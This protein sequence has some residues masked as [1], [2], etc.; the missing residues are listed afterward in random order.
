MTQKH[1]IKTGDDERAIATGDNGHAVVTG[2]NSY[3]SAT[4][5]SGI[6]ASF[7]NGA[8]MAYVSGAIVLVRNKWFCGRRVISHVFASKV[9]ENGIK[10]NTWYRLDEDGQ[11]EEVTV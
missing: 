5:K 11:P 8:A 2:F 7:D 10:P 6:A 1:V 9:G 4:G 3:A